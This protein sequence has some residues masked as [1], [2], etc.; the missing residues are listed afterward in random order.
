MQTF[1]FYSEIYMLHSPK[2]ITVRIWE[3][4]VIHTCKYEG[5]FYFPR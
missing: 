3:L 4:T 5:V 1:V 2:R